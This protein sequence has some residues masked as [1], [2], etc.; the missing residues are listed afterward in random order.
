MPA[1]RNL[2]IIE[3]NQLFRDGL[4]ELLRDSSFTVT[5]KVRTASEAFHDVEVA[6]DVVV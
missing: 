5:G 6:P 3:P 4:R 2:L 1:S